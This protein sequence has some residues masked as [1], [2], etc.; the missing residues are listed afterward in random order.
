VQFPKPFLLRDILSGVVWQ[1]HFSFLA[2]GY[3]ACGFGDS[4]T[5]LIMKD[6]IVVDGARRLRASLEFRTRLR[7]LREEIR[8]R[9]ALELKDA[10]FFR[11]LVLRWRIASEYRRER[12]KIV[13]SNHSLYIG[14]VS[15]RI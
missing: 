2:C 6:R 7:E 13:P 11:R 8:A 15:T 10:G 14:H 9:H 5:Y 12:R 4:I 1:V 3:I